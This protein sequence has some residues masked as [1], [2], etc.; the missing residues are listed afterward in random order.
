MSI[1]SKIIK[2]KKVVFDNKSSNFFNS[3]KIFGYLKYS[4]TNDYCIYKKPYIAN[5]IIA[6]YDTQVVCK[7]KNTLILYPNY[8]NKL[9][10]F[11]IKFNEKNFPGLISNS[12]IDLCALLPYM[13][14]VA[15][16]R[17]VKVIRLIVFTNKGQIYHNY[18]SRGKEYECNF[19]EEDI[20]NF[21]E[22]VVWDLDT[23][24]FPSKDQNCE[25]FE[26][27]YP[28]LPDDNYICHP[29]TNT[30]K[31]FKD[32]FHNGGFGK[33]FTYVEDGNK[34]TLPRFYV[35]SRH[36]EA[37]SFHYI[38]STIND[39][40]MNIIGTYRSNRNVGVRVCIFTSSDGGRSWFC[41]YE[42]A[43]SGEYEFMQGDENTWGHNYGNAIFNYEY[44][45]TYK[46]NSLKFKKRQLLF[47][48]NDQFSWGKEIAI[49]KILSENYITFYT[50]EKHNLKTG[51]II[52]L[53]GSDNVNSNLKWLLNNDINNLSCG[54]NLLFKVKVLDENTFE[55]RECVSQSDH[56]VC[57]RH[58]HHINRVKD[59]WIVGTGEIYPN[60]WL[61]YLQMK[62]S[63][64]F[65][66]K[67]AYEKMSIFKLTSNKQAVQRTMGL[68]FCKDEKNLIFA[69]DHDT[70]ELYPN[71]SIEKLIDCKVSHS[72][73]GV[74]KGNISNLNNRNYF[75]CIFD[76]KEPCFFFQKL[77]GV[78][79]FC[80]QRG[81]LAFSFDDG[82]N[83]KQDYIS[84]C[85]MNHYG[86]IG[87][88]HFFD[89]YI[90]M[91]KK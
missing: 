58:I 32:K 17:Y 57:C 22:S 5:K 46:E 65:S 76:A 62:E 54:N 26:R 44:H 83:W 74:F 18:P 13:R 77:N 72:S 51:N 23:A 4:E 85:F 78:L 68:I 35:Y 15:K 20:L 27:Y 39:S 63:D 36:P 80:G 59:G 53:L 14:E 45:L 28:G 31:Q 52:T 19:M 70:L 38:G 2:L 71:E 82:K 81:E 29:M 75:E 42:F 8:T 21:E 88:T 11:K 34:I 16:S 69:S 90:I 33:S 64:T 10:K 25:F 79:V 84:N 43:D 7:C 91:F 49:S 9:I 37:N 12:S 3:N 6:A 87:N 66:I 89:N 73:T 55:L 48:Q 50:N 60:G 47:E 67:N 24:K 86:S 56:N 41:K 40:K 61:L 1:K 30:D